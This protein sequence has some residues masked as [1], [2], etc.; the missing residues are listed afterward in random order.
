MLYFSTVYV[1]FEEY[2]FVYHI[3]HTNLQEKF[4]VKINEREHKNA[5]WA[6]PKEALVLPLIEDLDGCIKMFFGI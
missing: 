5:K 4:D 1:R 2:D 3:Y 6:T